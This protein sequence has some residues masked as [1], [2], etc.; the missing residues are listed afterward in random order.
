[1]R[2]CRERWPEVVFVHSLPEGDFRCRMSSGLTQ[3]DDCSTRARLIGYGPPGSQR[4]V[5]L[6]RKSGGSGA[7][8]PAPQIARCAAQFPDSYVP[9]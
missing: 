4:H 8:V 5:P 3:R 2:E 9:R 7:Q 1:M 6:L